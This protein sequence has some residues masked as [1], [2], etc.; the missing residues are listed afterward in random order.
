LDYT[1]AAQTGSQRAKLGYSVHLRKSAAKTKG[2]LTMLSG[3]RGELPEAVVPGLRVQGSLRLRSGQA[4]RLRSRFASRNGRSAQDDK[5]VR[6]IDS[7][8]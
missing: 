8:G 2:D 3:Y 1:L 5:F 7:S 6:S 4:L